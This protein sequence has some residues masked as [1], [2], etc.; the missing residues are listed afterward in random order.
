MRKERRRG[1]EK[2]RERERKEERGT[3]EKKLEMG[4]SETRAHNGI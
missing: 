1:W 3:E 4:Q 2:M